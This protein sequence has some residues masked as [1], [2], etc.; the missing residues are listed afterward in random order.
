MS[1][2]TDTYRACVAEGGWRTFCQRSPLPHGEPN[3]P[4]CSSSD[5]EPAGHDRAPR[6]GYEYALRPTCNSSGFVG[7]AAKTYWSR[8]RRKLQ[9][10]K[11]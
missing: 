7:R 2:T 10:G 4:M 5:W 6:E 11:E 9:P 3:A 1:I 8:W